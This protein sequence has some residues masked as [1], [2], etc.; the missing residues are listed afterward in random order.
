MQGTAQQ[1][2]DDKQVEREVATGR[3]PA[4]FSGVAG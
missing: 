4:R 2:G 3:V 1:M